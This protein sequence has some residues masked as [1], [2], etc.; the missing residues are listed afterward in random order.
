MLYTPLTKKALSICFAVHKAQ[1][2]KGG[3]PY[4]FH[5]FHLAEQMDSEAEICVALLHDTVEDSGL[6]I[7]DLRTAGFP[8]EV[9][10]AVALLTHED[11]LPYM[12]YIHRIKSLP[13]ARK[14]KLADLRHNA[15]LDRLDTPTEADFARRNKYLQAIALLEE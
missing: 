12:D 6:T 7:S 11:T 14:V 2:D 9:L 8:E 10:A 13:I 15:A 1:T 3:A 4:V 5:P